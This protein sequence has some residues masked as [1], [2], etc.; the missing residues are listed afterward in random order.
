M[1][2]SKIARINP[3]HKTIQQLGAIDVMPIDLIEFNSNGTILVMGPQAEID[4]VIQTLPQGNVTA[5]TQTPDE[6]TGWLGA[7]EVVINQHQLKFDVVLDLHEE[8]MLSVSVLPL[9]YFAPKGNAQKLA[10]ALQVIPDLIGTFDKPKYFEYRSSIC[11]HS[12]RQIKGCQQCIDACPAEAIQSLGDGINVNPSLCQGC[13]SCTAVCPSGAITY[14]LP[15]LD[16]SIDRLRTMMNAY[17]AIETAS[18]T[19][20]I[21]DEANGKTL[22]KLH[23]DRLAD[24]IIPFSIEEIGAL[25]MPF[26]LTCIAYGAG[27]VVV[28]DALSHDDHDWLAVQNEVHKT[29]EVLLGLGLDEKIHWLKSNQIDAL[30]A[31][32]TQEMGLPDSQR[33]TYAGIDDKRRMTAIALQHIH[34][35]IESDVSVLALSPNAAFGEVQVDKQACTLCMSCVSVCPVGALLDGGDK[36]QLNFIEDLCL[37]CGLCQTACPETAINLVSQYTFDREYA[38]RTRRLNEEAIFHCIACNKPFATQKM[39][40]TMMD[41]L[42]GHAMFQGPALERLK[43]CEDCRVKAMFRESQGPMR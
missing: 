12:R 41:K 33:A 1:N 25:G 42:K 30:L 9:G 24:H 26:W 17:F 32:T 8:A 10:E 4:H 38:R 40:D 15:T 27:R 11:A 29:N 35:S 23:S 13:G 36:P 16:Q 18:P 28:V 3:L 43:M 7:F 22:I 19:I 6:I 2:Q 14:A 37:Q 39:I 5:L 34:T 20:L 31:S 21:H